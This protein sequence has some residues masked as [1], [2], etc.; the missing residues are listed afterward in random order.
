MEPDEL[1]RFSWRSV[2]FAPAAEKGAL[3]RAAAGAYL[4]VLSG[5][6]IAGQEELLD[7]LAA[8]LRFPPYFGRNWDALDEMLRDLDWLPGAGCV[9]L[10]EGAAPLW[11]KQGR[12]AGRLVEAWLGAAETWAA[13]GAAFHLVFLW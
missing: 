8:A 7:R 2:H 11:A 3:A 1:R 13:G 12:A 6:G 5:A 10:V 4:A 9:V